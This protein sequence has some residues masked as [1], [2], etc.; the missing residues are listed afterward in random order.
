[1]FRSPDATKCNAAASS[2]RGLARRVSG[3]AWAVSPGIGD[4]AP[5]CDLYEKSCGEQ[6]CVPE[7]TALEFALVS[8]PRV[9]FGIVGQLI[10]R[11]G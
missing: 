1:M 9:K 8:L 6:V 7:E 10:D 3:T 2:G 4:W 5:H 11:S